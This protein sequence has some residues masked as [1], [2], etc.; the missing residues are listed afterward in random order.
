MT[1]ERLGRYQVAS[2]LS[3]PVNE[4]KER[5]TYSEFVD[6]ITFL[7]REEGQAKRQDY[8]MAQIA[9]EVRRSYVKNPKTVKL[10]DFIFETETK[11]EPKSPSKSKSI[12]AAVLN[13]KVED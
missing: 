8:Y 13:V 2:H 5:I 6:W 10:K 9:M 11:A 3:L 4:L 12:W 1:G 7:K